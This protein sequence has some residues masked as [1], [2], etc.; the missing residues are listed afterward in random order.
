[1]QLVVDRYEC[2][3]ANAIKDPENSSASAPSSTT[4]AAIRTFTSSGSAAS[5]AQHMHTNFT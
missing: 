1:M 2:E 5:A 4:S 3:W